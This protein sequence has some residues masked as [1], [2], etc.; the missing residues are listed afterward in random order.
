MQFY[1]NNSKQCLITG[2]LSFIGKKLA[3]AIVLSNCHVFVIQTVDSQNELNKS[4]KNI[5]LF[6]ANINEKLSSN[7]PKFDYIFHLAGFEKEKN[8]N[9]LD[10]LFLNSVGTKNVL[11]KAVEN[12]AKF[13]LISSIDVYQKRIEFNSSNLLGLDAHNTKK[14]TIGEARKY[15]ENLT[16]QYFQKYNLNARIVRVGDYFGP[17]M[18]FSSKTKIGN[19]IYQSIYKDKIKIGGDGLEIIY[20]TY[21]DD[22][23]YGISKAMF[24]QDSSGKIYDLANQNNETVLSFAN[25]IKEILGKKQ[26][27]I[28]IIHSDEKLNQEVI[29]SNI[30]F[31]KTQKDLGWKPKIN[32]KEG[33]E[34][35]LDYYLEQKNVKTNIAESEGQLTKKGFKFSILLSRRIL[36]SNKLKFASLLLIIIL[37]LG[38]PLYFAFGGYY[39]LSQSV[40][41]FSARKFEVSKNQSNKAALLFDCSRKTS[42]LYSRGLDFLKIKGK[43]SNEITI[44]SAGQNVSLVVYYLSRESGNFESLLESSVKKEVKVDDFNKKQSDFNGAIDTSIRQIVLAKGELDSVD[45]NS[46]FLRPIRGKIESAKDKISKAQDY[47]VASNAL[48]KSLPDLLALY[49]QKRY[50]VLFQN[51]YELRPTGGFIGSYGELNFEKGN[52]LGIKIDDIYNI[53]GQLKEKFTPPDPIKTNLSQDRWYL[54]DSNWDPDFSKNA[55]IA[56]EF[57]QKETGKTVDGVIAFDVSYFSDVIDSLGPIQIPGN[58]K[59]ITSKNLF[60]E[61]EYTSEVDFK[62]GSTAKKDFLTLLAS[63]TVSKLTGFGPEVNLSKLAQATNRAILEKHLLFY[64]NEPNLE[65]FI[66]ENN[67]GGTLSSLSNKDK[68]PQYDYLLVVDSNVG[69]NKANRFLTREI[70]YNPTVQ[71]DGNIKSIL[72]VTY[73]NNSPAA[74]WPGGVY[75]NFLRIVAPS[76]SIL[77]KATFGD[78]VITKNVSTEV[79]GD[80]Q[81]FS[82]QN[83]IGVGEKKEI[84]FEYSIPVVLNFDGNKADYKIIVQ[85]Q[86]GT[87]NDKIS[88]KLDFPAYLHPQVASPKAKVSNQSLLFETLLSQD[89]TFQTSFIKDDKVG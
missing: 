54:H 76:G 17:E 32:F 59:V 25:H 66:A 70:S 46:L 60:E 65:E 38:S 34:K 13:M 47:L 64:F 39:F 62:P 88:L 26:R 58:Q 37:F 80:K 74:T 79:S 35:T 18:D 16:A 68:I 57:Y 12:N 15:A 63:Q 44:A 6:T 71:R 85:K 22:L 29:P 14:P 83:E 33:L 67:F 82:V 52:L 48:V 49:G 24:G 1:K 75:K 72:K 56:E 78:K 23:I 51:N 55:K 19:L 77:E 21:I 2:G 10:F 28:E 73:Q 30:D 36:G 5:S 45:E 61:A 3:E 89:K 27:I 50:L 87:E 7:L 53:D 86:P 43:L 69:A 31:E 8:Q 11:E 81:V 40:K 9:D 84:T 42:E 41:N 4:N 20:P